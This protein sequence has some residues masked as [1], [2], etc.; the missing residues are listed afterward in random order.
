M[1]DQETGPEEAGPA[2]RVQG[3]TGDLTTE[4]KAPAP[5]VPAALE[6]QLKSLGNL[7]DS[8][9]RLEN[10]LTPAVVS[11]A[12]D[13]A[14]PEKEAGAPAGIADTITIHTKIVRRIR[15]KVDSLIERMEI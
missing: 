5:R 6:H 8:V 3:R 14:K 13:E 2:V 12:P 7:M 11:P 10:K 15:A 1:A 4:A 9:Q